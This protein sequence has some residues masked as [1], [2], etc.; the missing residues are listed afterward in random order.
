MFLLLLYPLLDSFL[1]KTD[2]K[3]ATMYKRN[4]VESLPHHFNM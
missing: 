1:S 4:T 3:K 2:P